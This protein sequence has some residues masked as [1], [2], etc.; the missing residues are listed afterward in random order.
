MEFS[1]ARTVGS[2]TKR[3]FTLVE[4][5][6]VIA[7]IGVLVALLLPAVQAARE[8]ARRMSCSNNLKQIGL[9]LQ[10]YHD[11][12]LAFPYGGTDGIKRS[13]PAMNDISWHVRVLPFIEQNAV[14]D[15]VNWGVA[16]NNAANTPI[17]HIQIKGY[18]CPSQSIVRS[19]SSGEKDAAQSVAGFTT[20]YY[21][22]NGPQGT[23]ATTGQ[24]Y[25]N[26]PNTSSGH[27]DIAGDGVLNT[28]E[29]SNMAAVTDGTSNTFLVGE[30]SFQKALQPTAH[31]LRVWTRGGGSTTTTSATKNIEFPINS[32]PYNGSNNFND[33]SFGSQHP[34]GA[35]FGLVDG[36]V[37]LVSQ[38][39]DMSIYQAMASRSG[40]E[41]LVD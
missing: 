3:A 6:V 26:H 7:I 12:V 14:Y 22:V 13:T 31:S 8:A 10:N 27:G 16:Y 17:M 38:N 2:K 28:Y 25:T 35:L 1:C 40:G 30:I 24:V 32:T 18:F 23:N 33:I 4:L 15:K 21:G 11:T 29:A 34:A 9:A 37:R 36:S 5:L 20:H 39:I 41:S 19:G